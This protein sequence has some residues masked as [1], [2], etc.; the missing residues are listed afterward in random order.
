[1]SAKVCPQCGRRY[2]GEQRFCSLDGS[3]LIPE[4]SGERLIG[5]TLA[6]R[7]DIKSKLGEGGMGEV[8]LAEHVKM[9][10]KVAIK[11]MRG[12]LSKDSAAVGRFYREAE[13]AS[14]IS[15]PNV[16]AVYDFGD[17]KDGLVYLA[18]EF[19]DGEPLTAVLEREGTLNH[20]RASDI[21]SQTADALAA[22]HALGILHRDLK[23]DNIMLGRTRVKTDL[24]KLLDFGISRVI[25]RETQNLTSTGLIVGTPEY[26]SPEQ[27]SG[28]RLDA[29]ADVYALGLIAFRMLTG[30]GAFGSGSGQDVL[31]ARMTK[32]PRRLRDVRPDIQWPDALQDAL[33]RAL[34]SDPNVR[35][36]EAESFASD[37]YVAVTQLP[38]TADSEAYRQALAQR[39]ATPARGMGTLEPTPPTPHSA[40]S[41]TPPMP[42]TAIPSPPAPEPATPKETPR[43]AAAAP[44]DRP[45]TP[46]SIVIEDPLFS[47]SSKEYRVPDELPP[48]TVSGT[49]P[50]LGRDVTAPRPLSAIA[51]AVETAR[52]AGAVESTEEATPEAPDAPVATTPVEMPVE[53]G[54]SAVPPVEP[55]APAPKRRGPMLVGGAAGVVVLGLL[56][57]LLMKGQGATSPPVARDSTR[58]DSAA[59]P[60]VAAAPNSVATANAAS[61]VPAAAPDRGAPVLS[62]DAVRKAAE[63]GVFRVTGSAG[64]G[65]A[66]LT[67]KPGL[68]LTSSS[69]LGANDTTATLLVDGWR[70]VV[71]RVV[72]RNATRGLAALRVSLRACDK[73][74]DLP[75]ADDSVKLAT[76][77]SVVAIGPASLA[78]G[79]HA[80]SRG[81]V[82]ARDSASGRVTTSLRVLASM[83]GGPVLSSR[84]V[85]IGVA[86][87]SGPLTTIASAAS[88]I[89]D[90]Q[91]AADRLPPP[92]I[93]DS[94]LP[95][96]SSSPVSQSILDKARTRTDADIKA[97]RMDAG[98]FSILV[99]TPQVMAWRQSLD[100]ASRSS[101]PA[102]LSAPCHTDQVCDPIER[103]PAWREYLAERRDVV[104]I[105]VT[106][107][108]A[109]PPNI[110]A[111]RDLINFRRGNFYSMELRRNGVALPVLEN[112]KVFAVAN[113]EAYTTA[114]KV[115]FYSGVYVYRAEDFATGQPYQFSIFDAT[116]QSRAVMPSLPGSLLSAVL[117]D[118]A[119]IG[120]AR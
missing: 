73:C 55:L 85:V 44:N 48:P 118:L 72:L 54:E 83:V 3:T 52:A 112:A 100:T 104:V 30:E 108:A 105:Q 41:P 11:V 87:T 4:G 20:I 70:R 80:V 45:R 97:F 102:N 40:M 36:A 62:T 64:Q 71:A 78:S 61:S 101:N 59:A 106:P 116:D 79:T 22:A 98:D 74:A 113:P 82:T 38:P 115:A 107:K 96:W 5:H 33:D 76:N 2:E 90:A 93:M 27:L 95:S 47:D 32:P 34:A 18:M 75:L 68:V 49:R 13:N 24:V 66:F 39:A 37:F 65:T 111:P 35:Y 42:M 117:A 84:G 89:A 12:A 77:D 43:E 6:D 94:A 119:E 91:K 114:N 1:M 53:T 46:I 10:R 21:V 56:A 50:A 110:G 69:V 17:T 29:R 26:M 7:Y 51:D 67:D 15:H 88:F 25:G 58:A 31:L 109:P 9:K 57:W 23:P 86:K 99:M 14:Q 92:A 103:W 16:A 120:R 60:N 63:K 28:D 19:V 8:Y 81:V